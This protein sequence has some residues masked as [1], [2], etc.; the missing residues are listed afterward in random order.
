MLGWV[1]GLAFH[2]SGLGTGIELCWLVLPM[3]RYCYI[4]SI[5]KIY[6]VS[7]LRLVL[8]DYFIA[9]SNLELCNKK[10]L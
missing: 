5:V 2:L 9:V 6:N 3:A 4:E 1:F 7:E 10:L 8:K